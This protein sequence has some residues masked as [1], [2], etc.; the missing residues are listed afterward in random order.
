[1]Q[2]EDISHTSVKTPTTN[3][4]VDLETSPSETHPTFGLFSSEPISEPSTRIA[5]QL[6]MTGNDMLDKIM[7]CPC[8]KEELTA[9][10]VKPVEP[11]NNQPDP[12]LYRAPPYG[13]DNLGPGDVIATNLKSAGGSTGNVFGQLIRLVLGL[14]NL[15]LSLLKPL[16]VGISDTLSQTADAAASGSKQAAQTIPVVSKTVLPEIMY[17][18]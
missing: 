10:G 15:L 7:N 8:Q 12:A 1:M 4:A 5:R 9:V 17:N 6:F 16:V 13:P 3:A 11:T 18:K 2:V 14:P